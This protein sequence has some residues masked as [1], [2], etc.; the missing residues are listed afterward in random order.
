MCVRCD[1]TSPV[2]RMTTRSLTAFC[3]YV[4]LDCS[5]KTILLLNRRLNISHLRPRLYFRAGDEASES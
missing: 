5:Q 1:M 3:I 2:F 4:S